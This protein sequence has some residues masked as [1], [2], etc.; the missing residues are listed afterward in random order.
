[1]IRPDLPRGKV[2][3]VE[4]EI[5][6]LMIQGS[7]PT[8]PHNHYTTATLVIN[9]VKRMTSPRRLIPASETENTSKNRKV[10]IKTVLISKWGLTSRSTATLFDDRINLSKTRTLK[11]WQLL[12]K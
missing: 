10:A 5:S 1:M 6:T 9:R 4:V 2:K 3:S 8:A 11:W 7:E 12:N